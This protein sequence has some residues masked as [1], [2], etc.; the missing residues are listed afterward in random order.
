MKYEEELTYQEFKESK[1]KLLKKEY[2]EFIYQILRNIDLNIG[3]IENDILTDNF[4]Q[5][6]DILENKKLL[7]KNKT[8]IFLGEIKK[9]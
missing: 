7:L 4:F 5:R 9:L 3:D 1:I 2:S 6:K 8:D